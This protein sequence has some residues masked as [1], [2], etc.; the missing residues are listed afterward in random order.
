MRARTLSA[1]VIVLR[2][3]VE[4][5]RVLLLRVYRNW[6]FP[7]GALESDETPLEAAI[8]EVREET[9]IRDLQFRLGH[10]HAETAPYAHNKVARYYLAWTDEDVNTLPINPVLGRAEHHEF[11][12]VSFEE[13]AQLIPPRLT[14]VWQWAQEYARHTSA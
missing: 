12:W 9:G 6:D 4:G 14:D 3:F 13:C 8:R 5:T 10:E 2:E 7:K 1:G 11:R